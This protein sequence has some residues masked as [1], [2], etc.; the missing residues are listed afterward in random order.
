MLE[1]VRRPLSVSRSY[2]LRNTSSGGPCC[3]QSERRLYT[4]RDQL[5][6]QF[7]ATQKAQVNERRAADSKRRLTSW[8]ILGVSVCLIYRT[9]LAIPDTFSMISF[10]F[11]GWL[12]HRS[13]Q[14]F[15]MVPQVRVPLNTARK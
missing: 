1:T 9:Y 10:L 13:S 12:R 5:K 6:V 4:L 14:P 2:H 11:S 7:R 8:V 3:L 15:G